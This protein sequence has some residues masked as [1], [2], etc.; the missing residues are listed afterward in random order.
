MLLPFLL[1]LTLTSSSITKTACDVLCFGP[2]LDAVCTVNPP[3]FNDSKTFV[4]L[5]LLRDPDEILNA[6]TPEIASNRTKLIEFLAQYFA[7]T[8]GTDVHDWVPDDFDDQDIPLIAKLTDPAMKDWARKVHD[9]WK[10]L[11]KSIDPDVYANPFRHTLLPLKYPYMIVPG[12]R[13]IEFYYWDT[14]WIIKGLLISQ[15]SHTAI[16]VVENLLQLANA[17]GFVPNGSRQYYLGRSQPPYLALMVD[18][19]LQAKVVNASFIETALPV[20]TAEYHWWMKQGE[21][22]VTVHQNGKNYILN[23]FYSGATTPR[24][25]SARE[26]MHTAAGLTDAEKI[27]VYQGLAAGAEAGWDYSS[28]WFGDGATLV[29]IDTLNVIPSDLN[30]LL[31]RVEVVLGQMYTLV[32]KEPPVDYVSAAYN[33]KIAIHA[34]LWDAQTTQWR[35]FN[36]TSGKQLPSSTPANY[37]GL[38]AGVFDSTLYGININDVAISFVNASG[39]I[40]P[41]GVCASLSPSGQQWDYPNVWPPLISMLVDGFL[42]L[43]VHLNDNELLSPALAR[44][45]LQGAFMAFYE[46]KGYM[47]E[48]Y[49]CSELGALGGGGEYDL[50]TGFGWTN[51]VVLTLLELFPDTP[52]PPGFK[53]ANII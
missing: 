40:G 50:Q 33:R 2:V 34:V 37:Q 18:L 11:G 9:V 26:D 4:D 14:Y 23:R 51:G 42:G 52:A 13:F 28:R 44:T 49:N 38:W 53:S 36:Y 43:D 17:T 41:G 48:K 47:L 45:M 31:Y 12:G 5:V 22:A 8:H 6:F 24:A 32:G 7:A 10:T 30:G 19:L 1:L 25:E 16:M 3:V 29:T 39:L 46:T 20:L 27:K 21:H 35:D 15:M